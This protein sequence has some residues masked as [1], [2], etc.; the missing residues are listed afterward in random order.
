MFR[1]STLFVT[2][3]WLSLALVFIF[4]SSSVAFAK[5][6]SQGEVSLSTR[7]FVPDDLDET[8]DYGLGASFRLDTKAR[9]RGG[10]RQQLRIFGRAAMIDSDR[11]V[12]MVEDAWAGW[13]N[14]HFEIKAGVLLVD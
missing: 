6:Q 9:Q 5:V 12:L 8:E 1:H 14:E 3:P 7:A 13:R 10:F 11:S 4:G 2:R